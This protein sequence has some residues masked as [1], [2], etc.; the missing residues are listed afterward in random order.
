LELGNWTVL[1]VGPAIVKADGS[2]GNASFATS[3]WIM[4]RALLVEAEVGAN[5]M[6]VST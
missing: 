1:L 2:G 6:A 4:R 3:Y 5:A